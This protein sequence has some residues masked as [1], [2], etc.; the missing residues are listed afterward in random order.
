LIQQAVEV[1]LE[2]LLVHHSGSLTV[3]GK[4]TV[5]RNGYLPEQQI[6]T[7]IEIRLPGVSADLRLTAHPEKP[8]ASLRLSLK[9]SDQAIGR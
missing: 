9:E 4:T 1:E 8:F 5:V 7:A 6:L 3:D 2:E